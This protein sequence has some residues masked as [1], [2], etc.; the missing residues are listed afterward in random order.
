MLLLFLTQKEHTIPFPTRATLENL[1]T[2]L[3]QKGMRLAISLSP[4]VERTA[5]LTTKLWTNFRNFLIPSELTITL[6][7]GS[8]RDGLN[9][10]PLCWL[11]TKR[12]FYR[13]VYLR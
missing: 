11:L 3:K 12:G 5:N 8:L 4:E 7:R 6:G 1:N 2:Y 9:S 13:V 10:L